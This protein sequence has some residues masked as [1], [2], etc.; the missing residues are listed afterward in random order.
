MANYTR[1]ELLTILYDIDWTANE[2]KQLKQLIGKEEVAIE[3]QMYIM[4]KDMK[5]KVQTEWNERLQM[6]IPTSS[7]NKRVIKVEFRCLTSA[8]ELKQSVHAFTTEVNIG[9][10]VR[11]LI[12]QVNTMRKVFKFSKSYGPPWRIFRLWNL[13]ANS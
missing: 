7:P 4:I 13:V 2:N 12:D 3:S 11:E 5:K 9:C 6:E 8:L 1:K 10:S